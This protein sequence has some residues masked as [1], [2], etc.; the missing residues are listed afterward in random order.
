MGKGFGL[1]WSGGKGFGLA[2]SAGKG[3]GLAGG[4]GRVGRVY[5]FIM[6]ALPEMEL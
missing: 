2:W 4:M 5:S 1:A 6:T 3:F